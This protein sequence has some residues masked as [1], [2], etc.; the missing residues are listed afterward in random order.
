MVIQIGTPR[1]NRY[2]PFDGQVSGADQRC[3]LQVQHVTRKIKIE[4]MG[5]GDFWV[6]L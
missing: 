1:A 6:E 2:R 3:R 5:F 4:W